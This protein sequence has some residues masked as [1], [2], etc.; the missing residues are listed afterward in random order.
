M[1]FGSSPLFLG[2][3]MLAVFALLSGGAW[4]IYRN[5]ADR[6]RGI[7]MLV[8]AVVLLGN[9]LIITWPR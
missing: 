5:R 3:A 6:T 2:I 7:L 4:L 8:A 1:Q 9:I